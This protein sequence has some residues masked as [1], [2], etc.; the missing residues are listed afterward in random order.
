MR[1]RNFPRHV[2]MGT[3]IDLTAIFVGV[4]DKIKIGN[5][6]QIERFATFE[7]HDESSVIEV[8][9]GTIV[10]SFAMLSAQP[11]GNIRIGDNCSI[12]PYCVL[13]GHG[14][15]TIGNNVR[16]ATHTVIIPANHVFSDKNIPIKDQGL[17]KVGIVI[18][19]DVWVGA[20][21]RILDGCRIGRGAIIGA[22]AV[23]TKD[24]QPYSVVVGVP[25]K[26]VAHR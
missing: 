11:G 19:D 15:L 20:G 13:Y 21:V 12:N 14:G 7:C 10:K 18:G 8:G 2:G 5:N 16:I 17:T 24:V 22:G 25:A 4:L 3:Y 6:V 9:D 26:M 1:S 23:V